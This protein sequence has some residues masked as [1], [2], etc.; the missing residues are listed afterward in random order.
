MTV[1]EESS[2]NLSSNDIFIVCSQSIFLIIAYQISLH[3]LKVGVQ[4]IRGLWKTA[5]EELNRLAIQTA[6]FPI[7]IKNVIVSSE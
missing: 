7:T 4:W 5:M 6:T 2:Q 1:N 3:N